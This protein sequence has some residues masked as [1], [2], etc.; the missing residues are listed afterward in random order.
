MLIA[1]FAA[2]GIAVLLGAVLAVLYLRGGPA[3]SAL[4]LLAAFHGL[5]ATAGLIC[6]V[7]A[8]GGPSRG[9]H[10]GTAAFGT[11]AACLIALAA[12][13]G[14]WMFAGYLRGKR[15]SE[16]TMGLH[17]TLAVSGFVIL[18]AYIFAG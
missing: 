17:A 18:A 8:L 14:G 6:L 9:G 16:M 5:L 15:R 3:W 4:P 12:L 11:I 1:A 2:L 10:M 13:A 7:L